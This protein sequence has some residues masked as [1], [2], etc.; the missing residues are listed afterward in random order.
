M[1]H[2][3]RAP[4][5]TALRSALR[6]RRKNLSHEERRRLSRTAS[7]HLLASPLWETAETVALYMALAEEIDTGLLLEQA[8][9]DGKS[10][11][12]PLCSKTVPGAMRLVPCLKKDALLPGP[13]GIAEPP[14]PVTDGPDPVPGL[15]IVPGLAFDDRGTRLG[16]GGGYY[17]RLLAKPAYADCFKLGLA[18]G[19]QVLPRLPRSAWDMPMQALC[20]E[21]GI[22]R[23]VP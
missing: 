15:I 17:D 14:R 22:M 2:K 4:D 3:Q 21:N 7:H 18:Y 6:E 13:F 11:L 9:A 12:L 19:F 16:Q 1:A 8:W 23:I 5:K 10:V 20:T